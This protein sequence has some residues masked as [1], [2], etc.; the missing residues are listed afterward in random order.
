[1][2]V[3]EI[4]N[5]S[6]HHH[7]G[8]RGGLRARLRLAFAVAVEGPLLLGCGSHMGSGLFAA[9]NEDGHVDR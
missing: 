4:G 8:P 3:R 9:T 6:G 2:A 1:M 5:R 7:I